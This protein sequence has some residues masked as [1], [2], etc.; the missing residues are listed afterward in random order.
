MDE[1]WGLFPEGTAGKWVGI[2]GTWGGGG[3]RLNML[4]N[5]S[6]DVTFSS[7]IDQGRNHTGGLGS[8]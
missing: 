8:Q 1:T 4:E 2:E 6:L 5:T 3:G 7:G